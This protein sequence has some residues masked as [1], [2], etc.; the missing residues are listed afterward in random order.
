MTM[1]STSTFS[2]SLHLPRNELQIAAGW[3]EGE[4]REGL[5]NKQKKIMA[6]YSSSG[7]PPESLTPRT[8]APH[9]K[10]PNPNGEH[11]SRSTATQPH[12]K[13]CAYG[14]RK[15][16]WMWRYTGQK[17]ALLHNLQASNQPVFSA[18]TACFSH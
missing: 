8:R 18:A 16:D 13:D 2:I 3:G 12:V 1:K 5:K 17:H 11:F 9:M 4:K 7:K 10:I 15:E 14:E 6:D